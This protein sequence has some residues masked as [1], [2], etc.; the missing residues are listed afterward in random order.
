LVLD[1]EKLARSTGGGNSLVENSST[2]VAVA[3][4]TFTY[5]IKLVA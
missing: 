2:L 4:T 1:L 3:S 5:S